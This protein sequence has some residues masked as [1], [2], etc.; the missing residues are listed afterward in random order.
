M[1]ARLKPSAQNASFNIRVAR[2]STGERYPLVVDSHG[3]PVPLANQWMLFIRR[4]MVQANSLI[5]EGRTVAHVCDWAMRR[6]IPLE[7]RLTSGN[8]LTP[9]ELQSL[10]QNLR[11]GRAY[12]RITAAKGL[13]DVNNMKVVSAKVHG[14]RV[15]I[16]RE[17]LIWGMETALYRLNV[18]D[19]RVPEIRERCERIRRQAI[20]FQR[21]A[22]NSRAK[23]VGLDS[24]QRARL[25]EI[26][27]PEYA[28]N[29][30]SRNVKF[31]NWVLILLLLTFGFRRGESL[32]LLVGDVNV[33]GRKPSLTVVR[34]PG[35]LADHRGVEPAVKTLG[36]MIYLSPDMAAL[37]DVFIQHHRPQ[38]PDAD[39]SPF[40]FFSQRGKPLSLRSVNA[41]LEQIVNCYPELQGFLTPH[42]LRYTY[43]DMLV[44]S[45]RES[46]L[47][48]ESLK[49][50]QN[51]L[52]GWSLTSEQG[53]L[54]SRRA[55]EDQARE[56]SI[57]HQR[58]LFR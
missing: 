24:Q 31:R 30:F 22:S 3:L 10:Y 15:G 26:I 43:N 39:L 6:N 49:A 56:I 7:E 27:N 18:A 53:S 36:R 51:Y 54:Y 19:P 50:A 13:A 12:G 21:K 14:A 17:F 42:V 34:R 4:P 57:A 9:S 5:E 25:L 33:K 35:D 58:S 52:N 28:G 8:G 23:R 20:E 44:E 41:I 45:A 1:L 32:K 40:L 55:I 16:A 38:F 46:G 11:Y 48:G 29:P 2:L 47:S 37:L